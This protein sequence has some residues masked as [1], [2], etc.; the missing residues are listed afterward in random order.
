[1]QCNERYD[2]FVW[3]DMGAPS[4]AGEWSGGKNY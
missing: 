4:L 3:G 1:M 2:V